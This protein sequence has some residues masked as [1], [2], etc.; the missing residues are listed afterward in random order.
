[1]QIPGGDVAGVVVDA[2]GGAR[3]QPGTRVAFLSDGFA[4]SK[5]YGSYAEYITV[6]E[7]DVAVLPEEI[8]FEEAAGLPL[9]SLTA[10][11]VHRAGQPACQHPDR[12]CA[13]GGRRWVCIA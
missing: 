10:L 4:W 8:G 12:L 2:D 11:Q 5:P 6:P 1:V 9:V 13:Q 7:Q 3:I